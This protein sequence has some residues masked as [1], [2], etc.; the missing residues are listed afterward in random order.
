ML[1]LISQEKFTFFSFQNHTWF[2]FWFG[3]NAETSSVE[4]K[5]LAQ[6]S[7]R[8]QSLKKK[9]LII[10]ISSLH[11]Q[12]ITVNALIPNT[13]NSSL[14]HTKSFQFLFNQTNN[15]F[16]DLNKHINNQTNWDLE[17]KKKE[18]KK[19]LIHKFHSKSTTSTTKIERS[20]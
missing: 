14:S 4:S 18:K 15:R 3:G 5:V 6:T 17:M 7:L 20:Q 9:T 2:Y 11:N 12:S 8:S 19:N 10:Q 1:K 16:Q 13:N